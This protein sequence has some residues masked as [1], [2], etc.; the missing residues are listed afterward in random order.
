[1]S[2]LLAMLVTVLALGM[3][4]AYHVGYS[5]G[6]RDGF[7]QGREDGK[8][9]GAVRAYAVGYDRGRHDRQAAATAEQ[10]DT[11]PASHFG[12]AVPFWVAL[13]IVVMTIVA[14]ATYYSR[15]IGAQ[16]QEFSIEPSGVKVG[17]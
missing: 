10:G 1:M 5:A 7:E 13:I 17:F 11:K 16:A 2:T 6:R 15:K 3:L 9:A 8:K 14:A 4:V 12:R